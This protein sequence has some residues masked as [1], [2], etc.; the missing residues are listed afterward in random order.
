M[1]RL[2]RRDRLGAILLPGMGLDIGD[3]VAEPADDGGGESV[4]LGAAALT[5]WD[6]FLDPQ[7]TTEG[8]WRWAR[9]GRYRGG[10]CR[11]WA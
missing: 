1:R 7:M 5:A 8:Y 9:R 3:A 2:R 6:L 11:R 4:V 10:A